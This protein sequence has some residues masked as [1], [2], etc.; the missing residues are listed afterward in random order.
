M[1]L[2]AD[3]GGTNARLGLSRDHHVQQSTIQSY[4]NADWD[5]FDAILSDYCASKG[6]D[7]LTDMVL[8][9]AGPVS[10]RQARLTNRGWRFDA[11]ALSQQYAGVPVVLLNDLTALGYSVPVLR[12]DQVK[13]LLEGDPAKGGLDQ[14]LVAG[15]GT[16]FNVSPVLTTPSLTICPPVEAGHVAMP[17]SI[18]AA[19]E[20]QGRDTAPFRT[21]EDLFSGRGF[22]AFCQLVTG[23]PGLQGKEAMAAFGKTGAEDITS[24]VTEY[25]GLLG[26]LLKELALAYMPSAGVYIA[27]SVGRAIAG[28]APLDVV[29]ALSRPSA[30]RP[31]GTPSILTIEDDSAAL[32]GC[33]AYAG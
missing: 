26:L 10:D 21:V 20:E 27:G 9:V 15:V 28:A 5:G 17:G 1:R 14:R 6:V 30:H 16:G 3:I 29:D 13:L 32:A 11:A 19:L 2:I 12:T 18:L 24:A 25:A 31:R 22:T 33:A 4:A 8:A 23:I 7:G